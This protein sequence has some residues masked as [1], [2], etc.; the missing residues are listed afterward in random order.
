VQYVEA[1]LRRIGALERWVSSDVI[2][3]GILSPCQSCRARASS[4]S[5]RCTGWRL[6]FSGARALWLAPTSTHG[7]TIRVS[8]EGVFDLQRSRPGR[9]AWQTSPMREC[10]AAI[11]LWHAEE[12]AVLTRQHVDL[13]NAGQPGTVW[14]VQLGGVP[15]TADRAWVREVSPARWPAW[16]MDFMLFVELAVYLFHWAKWN[17]LRKQMPWRG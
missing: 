11:T 6:E 10:T 12:D 1:E 9:G 15:S 14:H 4:S 8:L 13:A 2:W 7:K 16:P 3:E 17:E 5:R